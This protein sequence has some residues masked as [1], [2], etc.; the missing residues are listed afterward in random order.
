MKKEKHNDMCLNCRLKLNKEQ[1]M[2]EDKLGKHMVCQNCN[3]SSDVRETNNNDE[4]KRGK[5]N[6]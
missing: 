1:E 5:R 6:S 3:S 4:H 2:Y